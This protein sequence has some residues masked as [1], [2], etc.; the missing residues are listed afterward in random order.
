MNPVA[1]VEAGAFTPVSIDKRK[2]Y[3]FKKFDKKVENL[4]GAITQNTIFRARFNIYI[5]AVYQL[6]I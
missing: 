5:L 3:L 4:F 2:I 1:D 6:M